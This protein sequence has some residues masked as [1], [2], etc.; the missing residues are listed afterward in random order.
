MALIGLAV[1]LLHAG[2]LPAAEVQPQLVGDTR[3]HDPSVI[4]VDGKYAAFGT[5]EQGLTRGAIKVKTSAD[6]VN[7]TDAG[8][9]G[10]GVPEWAERSA[11]L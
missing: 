9:I 6:G 3:I 10:K 7:W 4:E 5:G 1:L 11:G 2:P 8:A